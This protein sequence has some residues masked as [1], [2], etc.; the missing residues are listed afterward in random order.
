MGARGMKFLRQ[1]DSAS[2][3]FNEAAMVPYRGVT[4][5]LTRSERFSASLLQLFTPGPF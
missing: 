4:R 3:L 1:G 5:G 2:T